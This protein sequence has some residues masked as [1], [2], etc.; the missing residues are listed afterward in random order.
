MVSNRHDSFALFFKEYILFKGR[1]EDT[2][3][4]IIIKKKSVSFLM[5]LVKIVY[6]FDSLL[7]SFIFSVINNEL[8]ISIIE[9]SFQCLNIIIW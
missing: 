2:F 7:S 6:N 9:I 1:F 3:L 8:N 4:P 5:K